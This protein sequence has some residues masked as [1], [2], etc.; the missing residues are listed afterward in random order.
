MEL[1][2]IS[3]SNET[4]ELL[5]LNGESD[6]NYGIDMVQGWDEL[7]VLCNYTRHTRTPAREAYEDGYFKGTPPKKG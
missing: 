3:F 1:K 5:E 4:R 6:C 2:D 7:A